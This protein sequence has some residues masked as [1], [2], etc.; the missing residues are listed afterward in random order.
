MLIQSLN[1]LVYLH[2][3]KKIIHRDIK[4]DNILLDFEGNLKI[5]DFGVSAI[6]SE[7]VEDLLKCH[8]TVA[9]AIQ[10]MS[11]EMAIGGS[12]DFK[13]DIYMLGLTFFFF[14]E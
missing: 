13:S 9:G 10:F 12:Y 7:E 5:S 1:A 11:P 3:V 6:K 8:N 14:N 4:P 2:E